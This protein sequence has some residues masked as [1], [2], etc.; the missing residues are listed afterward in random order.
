[1]EQALRGGNKENDGKDCVYVFVCECAWKH[2][3]WGQAGR[4][5]VINCFAFKLV[6]NKFLKSHMTGFSEETAKTKWR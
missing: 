3:S 4:Y 6:I 5:L 2:F 1:M